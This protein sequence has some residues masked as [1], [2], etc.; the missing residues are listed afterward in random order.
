MV[1]RVLNF[2]IMMALPIG[3]AIYLARRYKAGWGLFG[4]GVGSFVVSQV[5]HIPFNRWVLEPVVRGLGLSLSQQGLQ[6]M[7]VGLLYGASAGVFEEVTRA[8]G[9]RF[10]IKTD[11]DWASGLMYGAGHGGIEAILLGILALV[12]FIQVMALKG[13]DLSTVVAPDQVDLARSQIEAYLAVP[14]YQAILGAVERLSALPI[15]VSLS[16]LV[17]Q[18]FRRRQV[19]WLGLA[20]GWHTLVDAAA[21]FAIQTWNIYVTEAIVGV[22]GLASVGMILAFRPNNSP[23][24]GDESG[25]PLPLPEI[26]RVS[27]S[28]QNIED[29]RYESSN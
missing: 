7:A 4:I 20:I 13:V 14:W 19:W 11:R 24:D 26:R 27:P 15:Q 3:L 22:M 23:T 5:F 6:L 8:L 2:I 12:A 9:Y 21:V 25:P 29:S 17:L 28:E 16:V 10:L 18:A 1:A